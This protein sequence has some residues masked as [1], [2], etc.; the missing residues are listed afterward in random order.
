M[1][2]IA[3][4]VTA[5]VILLTEKLARKQHE[6]TLSIDQH[7]SFVDA[8]HAVLAWCHGKLLGFTAGATSDS[9]AAVTAGAASERAAVASDNGV[10]FDRLGQSLLLPLW[11]RA[12]ALQQAGLDLTDATPLTQERGEWAWVRWRD[13]FKK[14]SSTQP[15]GVP[16]QT[17]TLSARSLRPQDRGRCAVG[18]NRHH[19]W[20]LRPA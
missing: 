10:L 4:A 18:Q 12:L 6:L 7:E 13:D 3:V 8:M 1:L 16:E 11:Y 14:S 17:N 19:F 2:R 20:S 9:A 15:T 5:D